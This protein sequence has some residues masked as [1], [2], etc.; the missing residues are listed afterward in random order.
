[1]DYREKFDA[2]DAK[3]EQC[4]LALSDRITEFKASG[5]G[6]VAGE[7]EKQCDEIRRKLNGQH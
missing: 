6:E 3:I 2:I 1:M 5:Q 4:L 7:L